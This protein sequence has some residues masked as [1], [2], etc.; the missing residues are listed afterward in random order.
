[1]SVDPGDEGER[2]SAEDTAVTWFARHR[3][4]VL[5]NAEAEA[6]RVWLA[7]SPDH[8]QAWKG[9]EALWGR[10]D[11]VRDAPRIMALRESVRASATSHRLRRGVLR[12]GAALAAG[13]ALAV[14]A[15]Q[16]PVADTQR[17]EAS[18]AA[19]LPAGR[20]ARTLPLVRDVS[21]RIGERALVELADGSAVTLNTDSAIH[22]DFTG[23]ERRVTLLRGEAY[24]QVARDHVHPFIVAA[25]ARQVI[26]VGTA[27][28]VRLQPQRLQVDLVQGRV[29]IERS[30][31]GADRNPIELQAGSS[32]SSGADGRDQVIPLDMERAISWRTGKLVFQADRLADV[33]AEMNRYSTRKIILS[34]AALAER[35]VSGV[36]DATGSTQ[37]A[38]TLQDYGI[39][40]IVRANESEIVLA[41]TR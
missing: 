13:L 32:L 40:R 17:A 8:V 38:R 3:G 16:V 14:F 24:F 30:A 25:G 1:M 11:A 20:N 5:S 7:A 18:S 12:W 35:R 10:L 31:G 22:S 36:F 34:D 19:L 29:R 9:V 4:G 15:W 27:F 21:T 23:A 37:M 41:A 28:N 39:A 6:F 2:P 26:A 33:A